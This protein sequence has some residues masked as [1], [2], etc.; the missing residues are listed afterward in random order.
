VAQKITPTHFQNASRHLAN[1]MG[2]E[3]ENLGIL[4]IL[5]GVEVMREGKGGFQSRRNEQFW[6]G[7]RKAATMSRCSSHPLLPF[8]AQHRLFAL[9]IFTT[10]GDFT[11]PPT[12][13]H[14]DHETTAISGGA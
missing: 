1:G 11:C 7:Y 12:S 2:Y 10:S 4:G 9:K 5:E 8:T 6:V 3:S 14:R 13:G